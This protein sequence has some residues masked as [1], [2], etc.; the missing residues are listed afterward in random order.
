MGYGAMTLAS[1]LIA[2]W[3]D[4]RFGMRAELVTFP[5]QALL[6]AA[7]SLVGPAMPWALVLIM[8]VGLSMYLLSVPIISMFMRIAT[9]RHPKAL[10]LASSIEPM[11]FNVGIAFGTA[12]GGVVVSGPGMGVS[13][14]VGAAFSLVACALVALTL[15]IDR[16]ALP[17]GPWRFV[18]Q[19]YP[20]G[21]VAAPVC[22]IVSPKDMR[23]G[24][25]T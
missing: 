16:R 17:S 8:A 19:T 7:L 18:W 4:A 3:L 15:R 23:D 24:S 1:N 21:P 14:Y 12:V 2:G 6:L 11:A 20:C 5:V 22:A 10:T 13:G 9:E 25:D